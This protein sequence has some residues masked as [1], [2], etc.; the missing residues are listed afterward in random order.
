MHARFSRRLICLAAILLAASVPIHPQQPGAFYWVN[1]HSPK[2]QSVVVWVTRSLAVEN[3]TAIREIGVEYDAALVVTSF[4]ATPQSPPDA[5]T[6]SIWSV[7][8][9]SHLV[10]PL[11]HGVNLRWFDWLRFTRNAPLEPSILYDNCRQCAANTYFT[12]LYYDGAL[13]RWAARWLNGSEGVPVWNA[14]HPSGMDWTQVYAVVTGENGVAQLVTWNHFDFGRQRPA[15][16]SLYRYDVDPFS[17]LDQTVM[18][19]GK[20]ADAMKLQ[21]CSG[22]GAVT[23]LARGQD[24]ALCQDLLNS[25]GR[26]KP[27][28]TPPAGIRGHSTSGIH[29]KR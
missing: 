27:V 4:R 25:R 22:Q 9:T 29:A 2:D 12:T 26:R 23:G 28:S 20:E 8:L 5:D 11:L 1:F 24:S 13:H 6:F 16:D 18:L 10:T 17:G 15:E 21:L 19:S 14:S 7:S 3:W